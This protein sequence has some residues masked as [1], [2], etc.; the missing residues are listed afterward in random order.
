MTIQN[1]YPFVKYET[2][3]IGG[4]K[5]DYVDIVPTVQ[6][7]TLVA[8]AIITPTSSDAITYTIQYTG[9]KKT[10]IAGDN[11]APNTYEFSAV[12]QLIANGSFVP[13]RSPVPIPQLQGFVLKPGDSLQIKSGHESQQ[14]SCLIT[15]AT[16]NNAVNEINIPDGEEKNIDDA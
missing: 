2:T 13:D 6:K 7:T 10:P 3:S 5:E 9:A 12:T 4:I 14:F 11:V 15:T 16:F 8:S 1:V